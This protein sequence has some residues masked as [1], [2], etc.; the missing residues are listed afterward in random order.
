MQKWTKHPNAAWIN[1]ELLGPILFKKG[2]YNNYLHH[3]LDHRLIMN[4]F[5]CKEIKQVLDVTFVTGL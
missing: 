1:N 3:P 5:R 2:F 4:I